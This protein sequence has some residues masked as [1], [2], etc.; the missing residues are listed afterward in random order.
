MADAA[1]N[2]GASLNAGDDP[3]DE[4]EAA[5]SSEAGRFLA[6]FVIASL[7]IALT[8]APAGAQALFRSSIR[9]AKPPRSVSSQELATLTLTVGLIGFAV[10]ATV[11]LVR[12]RKTPHID[13]TTAHEIVT[14][15][16]EIDGLKALLLSEPQV[17]VA[18]EAATD[19]PEII[20]DTSIISPAA[21]RSACS[22]SAVGSNPRRRNAWSTR[23]R[24]CAARAAAL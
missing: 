2:S 13:R 22:L 19:E 14:L 20:G 6:A 16:A 18:W 8:P 3:G 21:C 24:R 9:C 5:F 15:N 23:S 7:G 10:L 1:R 11:M 17:L 4:R 12:A